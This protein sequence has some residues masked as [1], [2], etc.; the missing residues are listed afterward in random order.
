MKGKRGGGG[1]HSNGTIRGGLSV[2]ELK[3]MTAQRISNAETQVLTSHP[4]RHS[5]LGYSSA[6]NQN[7]YLQQNHHDVYA[8]AVGGNGASDYSPGH[9]NF[10]NTSSP[11]VNGN[12]NGGGQYYG[13]HGQYATK[14]ARAMNARLARWQADGAVYDGG[15]HGNHGNGAMYSPSL[16]AE[17]SGETEDLISLTSTVPYSRSG[18]TSPDSDEQQFHLNQQQHQY[19]D[20]A[21]LGFDAP[22]AFSSHAASFRP[23]YMGSGSRG[24][25]GSTQT[26]TQH[27]SRR[28]GDYSNP[29]SGIYEG[30]S[31]SNS[32][33]SS[34]SSIVYNSNSLGLD[35]GQDC[36][37]LGLVEDDHI[38]RSVLGSIAPTSTYEQHHDGRLRVSEGVGAFPPAPPLSSMGGRFSTS[39]GSN[40][41]SSIGIA[42]DRDRGKNE[43]GG[44]FFPDG[45]NIDAYIGANGGYGGVGGNHSSG[46]GSSSVHASVPPLPLRK[47]VTFYFLNKINILF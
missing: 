28:N 30:S 4:S 13:G 34:T 23:S 20:E 27:Q 46:L 47:Q 18:S 38:F 22:A 12:G 25:A 44:P 7:Q 21:G 16:S 39:G 3:A 8:A 19:Q 6:I 1:S 43:T 33:S 9:G 35:V 36:T 37:P 24:S 14:D 31:I 15:D 32:R 17:T 29:G 40:N 11:V 26:Q 10:R 41:S 42:R 5:H 45:S 2:Q